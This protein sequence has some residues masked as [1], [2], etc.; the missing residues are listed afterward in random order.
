MIEQYVKHGE[1][2]KLIFALTESQWPKVQWKD[3]FW[4]LK[5]RVALYRL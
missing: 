2:N 5:M 1:E 3:S 4:D